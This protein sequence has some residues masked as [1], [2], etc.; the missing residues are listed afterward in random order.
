MSRALD[1]LSPR[2]K[3]LAIELL[4]RLV[5]AGISVMIVDTLRTQAEHEAN[6]AKG[7]SWTQ[8][9]KHLDGDAIDV[10]PYEVYSLHG[11]DKLQWDY[12]D[13]IWAKIGSIG[14]RL[15]LRWGGR[16]NQKDLGHFEF[17]EPKP[18]VGPLRNA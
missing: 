5:E 16:W 9:S 14:E 18:N 7:V 1:D 4:A 13:P 11:P 10:C 12:G 17:Q 8:H 2:F 3:P 6:L 15:G